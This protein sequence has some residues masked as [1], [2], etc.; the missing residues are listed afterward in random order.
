MSAKWFLP[1]LAFVVVGIYEVQ[2]QDVRLKLCGRDFVRMVISS[3]GSSRLKRE[4]DQKN[5]Q[6]ELLDWLSNERFASL[7]DRDV[8]QHHDEEKVSSKTSTGSNM[9]F[10]TAATVAEDREDLGLSIRRRRDAGPAG[11][12]CRSGCTLSELVQYC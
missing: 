8:Q 6:R 9:G 2:G 4:T 7:T 3:C 5:S 12:C 11:V 1:L 10:R